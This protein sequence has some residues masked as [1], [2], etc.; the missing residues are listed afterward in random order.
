[1]IGKY[2][3][4][5]QNIS[6]L[7]AIVLEHYNTIRLNKKVNTPGLCTNINDWGMPE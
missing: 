6:E 7:S 2:E 3:N 5:N 1:M 4:D